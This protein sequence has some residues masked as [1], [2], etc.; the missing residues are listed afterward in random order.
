MAPLLIEITENGAVFVNETRVTDETTFAEAPDEVVANAILKPKQVEKWV[1]DMGIN[2]G[3]VD[4]DA[5]HDEVGM[6]LF[7][8]LTAHL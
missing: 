6:P 1:R 4:S 5:F 3:T 8:D 2:I 7:R